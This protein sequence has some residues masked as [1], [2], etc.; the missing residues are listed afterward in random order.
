MDHVQ[1]CKTH[2][3]YMVCVLR[4]IFW[5]RVGANQLH[6]SCSNLQNTLY[7][8]GVCTTTLIPGKIRGQPIL[9]S[10]SNLQN[11][12]YIYGVCTTTLIPGKIRGQPTTRIIFN[13]SKHIKYKVC[14][15]QRPLVDKQGMADTL[16]TELGNHNVAMKSQGKRWR[17]W[18]QKGWLSGNR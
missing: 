5:G 15:I 2:S 1:I 9:G 12:Q 13:A 8:Y 10:C 16:V 7:I 3:I 18:S 11:T 14:S 17:N 4:P 6:G